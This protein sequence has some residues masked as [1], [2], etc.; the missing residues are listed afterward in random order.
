[1]NTIYISACLAP[2]YLCTQS[3]L[4]LAPASWLKASTNPINSGV[5]CQMES[6]TTEPASQPVAINPFKEHITACRDDPVPLNFPNIHARAANHSKQTLIQNHYEKHRSN[7]NEQFKEQIF[8][9]QPS[10]W[11]F[12]EVLENVLKAEQGLIQY[13]DIRNNLSFWAR[14]PKNIRE[15]VYDIQQEIAPVAGPCKLRSSS[16]TRTN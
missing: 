3:P 8:N 15:L 9:S 6:L 2:I 16:S 4:F 7:R 13:E 1:M 5:S 14:P 12:D 11:K 10:Q